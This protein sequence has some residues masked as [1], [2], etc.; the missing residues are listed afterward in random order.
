MGENE[1]IPIQQEQTNADL[2]GHVPRDGVAR[3]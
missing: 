1:P 2:L 3:R